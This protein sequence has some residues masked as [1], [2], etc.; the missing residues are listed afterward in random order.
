MKKNY[1]TE[2]VIAKKLINN[3]YLSSLKN[4][5]NIFLIKIPTPAHDCRAMIKDK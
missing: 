2:E 4:L 3:L 1:I 5:I